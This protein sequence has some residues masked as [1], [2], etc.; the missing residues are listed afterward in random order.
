MKGKKKKKVKVNK[1]IY[2]DL[3]TKEEMEEYCQQTGYGFSEVIEMMW[4]I[5]K[6]NYFKK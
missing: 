1:M 2:I 6:K 5:H 3:D 4:A